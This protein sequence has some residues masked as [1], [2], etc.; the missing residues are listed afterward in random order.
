[1]TAPA[2]APRVEI[3]VPCN[4]ANPVLYLACCGLFDL[5]SRIDPAARGSWRA[6]APVRFVL[7]SA[8]SEADFLAM[9]L[10]VF[11][12]PLRWDYPPP[13]GGNEP[14]LIVVKLQ[15]PAGGELPILLDWWFETAELDG[16]IAQ[17]SAWKMFA[18]QQTVEKITRD[19]VAEAA[20]LRAKNKLPSTLAALLECEAAMSGRFGLDPRSSRNALDVGFSANDL[21]LPVMTALFTELLAVFGLA[22]FFPGRAGRAGRLASTRGW[23]GAD[24]DESGEKGFL[25]SPWRR[26][27][28]IALA[29]LAA[30]R[31]EFGAPTLFAP[32]ATRKNYS[33]L[34][35]A[36]TRL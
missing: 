16:A 12:D 33:N 17:K 14:T 15:P 9:L 22:S 21:G 27:L 18:G 7:E 28:P 30:V 31:P 36:T 5:L 32:R 20:G 3:E 10:N 26:S 29:R 11:C 1:M 8:V 34:T 2:T 35:L 6:D 23:R 4:P 24:D 25:Y 13:D 19:M